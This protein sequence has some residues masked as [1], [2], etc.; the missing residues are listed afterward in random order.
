MKLASIEA[1]DKE[2]DRP[3]QGI[4]G[5]AMRTLGLHRFIHHLLDHRLGTFPDYSSGNRAHLQWYNF[6]LLIKRQKSR[7]YDYILLIE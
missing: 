3:F 7:K 4:K 1:V 6:S 2:A 5:I